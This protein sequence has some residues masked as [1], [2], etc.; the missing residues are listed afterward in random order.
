MRKPAGILILVSLVAL[1]LGWGIGEFFGTRSIEKIVTSIP[2]SPI[3]VD[4]KY[5]KENHSIVYS[6][7]NPGGLPITI[8]NESFIF[9]PGKES[10]E[11]GY[12]ISHIPVHIV[13][14]PGVITKVEMKLKSGTEKLKVGDA[15]LATFS[16]V[17]PLSPDV[18]TVAHPFTMGVKRA[19]KNSKK[20]KE[21]GK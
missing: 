1:F 20:A 16:Y 17:H 9:T 6:M 7:L 18:Y 11:K 5:N 12:V 21:G 8:V 10:S 15:V 14:P 19:V 13:L 2:A 4:A 3:V